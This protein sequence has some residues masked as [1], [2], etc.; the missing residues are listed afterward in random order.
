M[1]VIVLILFM[2]TVGALVGAATNLL[3]IRMLFR[4]YRAY[5]IGRYQVPFTPGLLPKRQ[6]ELSVQLGRIVGQH[7]LTAEG[8]EK[9]L[10]ASPFVKEMTTWTQ[11]TVRAWLQREESVAYFFQKW[12]QIDVRRERLTS[13]SKKWLETKLTTFLEEN[14]DRPVE[15]LLPPALAQQV[16]DWL[17][18]AVHLFLEKGQQYIES[19][20]GQK[21]ISSMVERFIETK[22]KLGSMVSMFI[23]RE[24]LVDMLTPEIKRL[25]AD[26][27]TK[28]MAER[29]LQ[30]E[31]EKFQTRP[32]QSFEL[33]AYVSPI[34]E[35]VILTFEGEVPLLDW[36][37]APLYTWTSAYENNVV[38]E[39]V[40][41]VVQQ[42]LVYIQ[43]QVKSLLQKLRIE[44]II[45]VQ[46]ASLSMPHL[47]KLILAVTKQELRMITYFGG[48]IG[49]VV[50][51]LQAL[52]VQFLY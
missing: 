29:F 21:A 6:Q 43:G 48:L 45:Q 51:C 22:G 13:L 25:L 32:L 46:V 12:F 50:G 38:D 33:T 3:A 16:T 42:V 1:N 9:Q 15:A 2:A 8:I 36:L 4:P 39:W 24:K 49:A 34:S 47:E 52:I 18:K 28:E 5:K 44:E 11:E 37:D 7:L 10:G 27:R 41:N 31:W 40:P 26:E 35:K 14:K 23:S 30:Q 20:E 19:A 17:P